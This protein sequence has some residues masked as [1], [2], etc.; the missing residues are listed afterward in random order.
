M[1]NPNITE[2]ITTT[3]RNRSKELADNVTNHNALLRRLNDRGNRKPATGRTIVQELD[4]AAN[5]T[6]KFYGGYETLD[7]SEQDVLT[8]AEFDW[9]LLS[10]TVV[11]SGEEQ[12]KNSGKEALLDLLEGRI[13]N[14]KRS[15]M[16]T[17]ATSLYSDGTGD[18][19]KE[20]GGLQLLVQDDPTSSE[21]IGG[22]NQATSTFWQ[23]Q[24]YDFSV[25][26]VTSSSSTMQSAMNKLYL[27]CIRGQDNPDFGV[28]DEV[29]YTYFWESLQANQRFGDANTGEAGFMA[30]KY[31]GMDVFY[32]DQCPASHMYFLNT[33]YLKMRYHPDRDFV[34][35]E[36]RTSTN[37]DAM[38][39]P[40]FWAGN[41][42]VS[43]RARQGV[44]VE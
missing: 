20:I 34:P 13:N 42:C 17:L 2:I 44:I 26:S 3:L 4:Y 29:Y 35:G 16:N 39:V 9:K 12:V 41:M 18:G 28:A 14:L 24:I 27:R 32:D 5:E 7:T 30:L 15:L 21:S 40:I 22:I 36:A 37:Q 31:R 6:T 43:N 25:E 19:G 38:I 1:S 11:M 23:N 10:G 8:A 33:E